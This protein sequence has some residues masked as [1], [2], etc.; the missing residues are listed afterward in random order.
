MSPGI[1]EALA[2][3]VLVIVLVVAVI[4]PRGLSE[5]AVAVPG[6]LLLCLC[7]VVGWG[8]AGQQLATMLPTVVFLAGVLMLAELCRREGLF[9]AAGDLMA[10]LS[11]NRPPR[12]LAWVF[13]VASLI[14]AVLGLDATVVLLTPVVLTTAARAGVRTRPHAYATAHLANSASLLLPVSNLT[15]LLAMGAAGLSFASFAAAMAIPWLVAIG[16]EFVCLRLYF[17]SDLGVV[18]RRHPPARGRPLPMFPLV[19]LGI[20]LV[21]FVASSPLGFQPFWVALAAVAVMLGKRIATRPQDVRRDIAG[22]VAAARLPFLAFVF[23]LS[24][25]VAAVVDHGLVDLLRPLVPTGGDVGSLVLLAVVAAVVANVINNLPAILVL[26]P[27]LAHAG[28]ASVLAALI[29]VNVGPNLTYVG[30]LATL[31]WR[32]ILADRDDAGGLAVFTK[33]GLLT[34]PAVLVASTVSLWLTAHLLGW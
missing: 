24:V 16:I 33:L 6:A 5:A 7:G 27:L 21:G 22:V 23:A 29:G 34:V 9:D 2:A 31:L 10:R 18:T 11:G 25:I 1:A 32:R 26:L 4:R 15:N 12:L 20:T 3:G 14:T 8:Q 28:P 30:S 13:V 19:V 17:R